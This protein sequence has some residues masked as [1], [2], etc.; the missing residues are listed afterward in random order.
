[1]HT[2]C[3]QQGSLWI[4]KTKADTSASQKGSFFTRESKR[5]LKEPAQKAKK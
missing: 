3:P 2:V 1:M 4:R 5:I